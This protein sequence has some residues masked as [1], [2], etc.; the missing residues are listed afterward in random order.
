MIY[1]PNQ[2]TVVPRRA[3]HTSPSTQAWRPWTTAAR[4]S[5]DLEWHTLDS[6]Y[7]GSLEGSSRSVSAVP[8]LPP[9]VP[10]MDPR[11]CFQGDSS[12]TSQR[13]RRTRE[14][15]SCRGLHRW[16][17]RRSQKR[18]DQVGKTKRGKGSKIMAIADG[19][20]LPIAVHVASA[21][22]HEV[23]LVQQTLEQTY[24]STYP[25]HLI[26]DK[27]YDSDALDDKLRAEQGVELIAPHRANRQQPATQDGRRLRRTKRRWCVE[28]LFAWLQNFRRLV[29][30]Y[31]YYPANFLSMVQLGCIIILLRQF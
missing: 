9:L 13:S 6:T 23:T 10:G 28:R 7:W 15:Q 18:G 29:N 24:T 12:R 11:R 20:G 31:E 21:S 8:D 3:T 2:P 19:N 30:R 22:P 5:R 25:K 4:S 14:D 16:F 17:L 26:G 1:G 27:A